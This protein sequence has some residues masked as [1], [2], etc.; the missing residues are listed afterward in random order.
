MRGGKQQSGHDCSS[1][2][3]R[4]AYHSLFKTLH[5]D[6][7]G[8]SIQRR[9]AGLFLPLKDGSAAVPAS[10]A[11]DFAVTVSFVVSGGSRK[12]DRL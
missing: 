3:L 6:N 5:L 2:D 11:L 10:Q 1:A 8:G 4:T 12:L 9:Q 7:F